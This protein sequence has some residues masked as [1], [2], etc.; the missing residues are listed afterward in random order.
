[1]TYFLQLG[2]PFDVSCIFKK[3]HQLGTKTWEAEEAEEAVSYP[4]YVM[5]FYKKTVVEGL[6]LLCRDWVHHALH[7]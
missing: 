2:P 4:K 7:R 5:G 6:R 3:I 1:M